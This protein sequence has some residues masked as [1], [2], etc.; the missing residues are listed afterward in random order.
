MAMDHVLWEPSPKRIAEAQI[1]Q[2]RE[3]IAVSHSVSLPN[4]RSLHEWSLSNREAF[5][6]EIWEL[7]DVVGEGSLEP[8]LV[9]DKLPGARWFPGTRL[10][11]A[12][13]CLR[14]RDDA[15]A[16][17]STVEAQPA[18]RRELSWGSLYRQVSLVASRLRTLGVGPGVRCAAY[19]PNVPEAVVTMLAVTSLG[20]VWS[21]CSPDFG[22]RAVLDRLGQVQP[23]VL[24]ACDAYTYKGKCFERMEEI[25]QILAGLPSV[26]HC[27]LV[28]PG[29]R[30]P[31][32]AMGG[33]E[34]HALDSWLDG[35][36]N[37]P[38]LNFVRVPFGAPLYVMFSSGTTGAPKAMIH[39]VGGT[40]LQHIKEHR[41]HTDVK[42]DDVVFYFSTTG[43]MMWNW[44]VTV[45]ASNATIVLFD[46]NPTGADGDPSTL[47]KLAVAEDFTH[48]GTSAKFIDSIN[49][50]GYSPAA[51]QYPK[52]RT[53][54]S[55]GSV[56][57]PESYGAQCLGP[58]QQ[59]W[60]SDTDFA[61]W[62]YR[63][64]KDDVSLAS[65]TG[66]T[67]ILSCFVLGDPAA[68]VRRGE[69]QV[70]CSLL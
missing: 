33:T 53:I 34:F 26:T 59:M 41:L 4:Y 27:V 54:L 67:D 1:T 42:P 63:E 44:L 48:F 11:F 64:W 70:N 52:L 10:N 16:I 9:D 20:G 23:Q 50:S 2:F 66:G 3:H 39:S 38:E 8:A 31:A 65:I 21:S 56:L 57:S 19:I 6:Q 58:C 55:T 17:I 37:V 32:S 43:W 68:P 51:L 40:L 62:V 25:V 13:N 15:P 28:S 49:K 7:G 47:F 60:L 24:F 18:S 45:L 14:R 69:L 36:G 61:D 22:H 30:V 35:K 12:E 29:A 46:G 5:W